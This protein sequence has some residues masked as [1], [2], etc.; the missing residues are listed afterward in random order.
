MAK[1]SARVIV[2]LLSTSAMIPAWQANNVTPQSWSGV[3]INSGCTPEEAFAEADKCFEQRGPGAKLSLYDDTIR[4]VYDLDAQDQAAHFFGD[5]VTV[6]GTLQ[7]NM[8]HVAELKKLTAIGLAVGQK[9]PAFSAHDQFGR[10]HSSG[11]PE[12]PQR[13]GS[14]LFPFSRL[15]TLLQ[16][17]AGRAA[18]CQ[19]AI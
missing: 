17:A 6:D 18:S 10:E 13:H 3:I 5:S 16:R 8:I 7:G 19:S 12:R 2:A 9:A 15:V 14:T 4:Q 11:E 1:L